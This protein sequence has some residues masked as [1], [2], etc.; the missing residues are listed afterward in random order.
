MVTMWFAVELYRYGEDNPEIF[1]GPDNKRFT[2]KFIIGVFWIVL[3]PMM[4]T[5]YFSDRAWEEI[6][7]P[8]QYENLE[9]TTEGDRN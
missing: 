5:F 2:T 7:V 6:I 9:K 4:F 1:R 8:D 3:F